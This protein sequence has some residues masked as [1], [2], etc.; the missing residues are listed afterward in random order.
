MLNEALESDLSDIQGGTTREGVHLGAMAGSIDILQRCYSGF[1]IRGDVLWLHPLLPDELYQLEFD[2]RYR[3]HWIHLR[4]D[5]ENVSVSTKPSAAPPIRVNI[6]GSEYELAAGDRVTVAAQYEPETPGPWQ[7]VPTGA[8]VEVGVGTDG[9]T[10]DI[11]VT[12]ETGL[13]PAPEGAGRDAIVVGIGPGPFTGL[14]VGMVT[15][16]AFGDALGIP[17]HGVCSLDAIAADVRHLDARAG[18]DLLVVTDA[19]R[20]EIYWARYENDQRVEGPEVHKPADVSAA[21]SLRVAG[22]AA[23]AALF[24]VPAVDVTAPSPAGLVAVAAEALIS[25]ATPEPLVPLYLRRPDAVE[26]AA[27][28]A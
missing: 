23:H 15:A 5:H 19:R 7:P 12:A 24:D 3:D 27:R 11:D 16:A 28:K 8:E 17:V 10:A 4:C 13:L 14:R 22:S 20:R 2:I 21:P 9:T 18:D 25:G 6:H 1:D 26:T